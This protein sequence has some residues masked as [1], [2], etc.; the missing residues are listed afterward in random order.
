MDLR[1]LA[2]DALEISVIGSFSRIGYLARS[3]LFGWSPPRPG[4]L[5]GHTALVTGPTSGLGRATTEALAGLGA[6]VV[7]LGRSHDRLEGLEHRAH[8]QA[9]RRSIPRLS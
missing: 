8:G 6:R 9:R 5:A 2:D 3:S 4:A 7:L 1:M